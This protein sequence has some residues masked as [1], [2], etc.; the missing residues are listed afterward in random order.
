M[1]P[2]RRKRT[3]QKHHLPATNDNLPGTDLRPRW[4]KRTPQKHPKHPQHPL[5]VTANENSPEADLWNLDDPGW[6]YKQAQSSRVK[7]FSKRPL[8]D[9][10]SGSPLPLHSKRPHR[11]YFSETSPHPKACK[12]PATELLLQPQTRRGYTSASSS[13]AGPQGGAIS[14][15]QS[16][17]HLVFHHPQS[18]PRSACPD[19]I[20]E[21][22][23]EPPAAD[24]ASHI[25]CKDQQVANNPTSRIPHEDLPPVILE[26][27]SGS[28]DLEEELPR[29]PETLQ[30][31]DTP[32]K[33]FRPP[34][35]SPPR[36]RSS[37]PPSPRRPSKRS[38]PFGRWCE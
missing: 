14:L 36:S 30:C 6:L 4:M 24:L 19:L 2:R 5:P 29:A 15:P 38:S 13:Q 3:Q 32:G 31:P 1:R 11:D 18:L 26:I 21:V 23:L 12:R 16:N 22:G 9:Y 28:P 35:R 37:S 33:W 34:T 27:P 25:P 7:Q 20:L 8:R 17:C 10:F